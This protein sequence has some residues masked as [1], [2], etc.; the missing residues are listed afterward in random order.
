MKVVIN[1]CFG[2][3]S[4]SAKAVRRARELG[5]EWARPGRGCTLYG[6]TFS[7]GTVYTPF[8]Q[9]MPDSGRPEAE[10][11]ADPILVRVVEEMGDA[12]NGMCAKL[13]VVEIPDGVKWTI[14]EYDGYEHVAEAHRTWEAS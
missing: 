3:F 5:A 12:A 9:S 11:R 2:G 7:D 13:R 4:I 6:E 14:Q 8:S 1:A 10:Y